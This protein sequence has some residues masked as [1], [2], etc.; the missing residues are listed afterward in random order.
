MAVAG[1]RYRRLCVVHPTGAGAGG[2][3]ELLVDPAD[4]VRRLDG[5]DVV[6]G[7]QPGERGIALCD[8]EVSRRH[9]ELSHD[10]E[11]DM[12][13]VRDLGSTNGTF[14]DGR[15]IESVHLRPGSVVRV[16]RSVFVYAEIAFPVI[17]EVLND[18]GPDKSLALARAELL[19]DLA[20][21]SDA[22]VLIVGPT[23][24]GKER[25]ARRVH[26]ES[27][28]GGA[29][30]PVNCATLNRELI[31]SELFGH[32]KGAFS[33]AASDRSG[34]FVA[35][36]GGTLFLDEIGDLPID[37]QPALLRVIEER[38]IRPVGSD[39]LRPVDVRIVSA[40]HRPLDE[41][42]SSERFRPDL[43]SRLS[44]FRVEL[45]G[46]DERREEILHLFVSMLGQA[47]RPLADDAAEALLVH[48]WPKNV[49]E[50]QQAAAH[51]QLFAAKVDQI[52]L[53]LLPEP[54]QRAA[55]RTIDSAGTDPA[56]PSR[57]TLVDLLQ[58]HDGNVAAVARALGKGRQQVYRW[59]Q[60]RGID[61]AAY[62]S[63]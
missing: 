52:D 31:G 61:P 28:R 30:I 6:V 43:H 8:S 23:G 59:M 36:D 53:G 26:D 1:V 15:R 32:V 25:L 20:A 37:Q 58:T 60:A 13:R 11:L 40:T 16:G 38:T 42:E 22:P 46:L 33:G 10:A 9:A 41:L 35:A 57:Q 21:P 17:S 18:P 4:R 62:R 3:G 27:G 39:R 47:A 56:A 12:Y 2:D 7:R 51:A 54:I 49:R 48:D 24:A 50:L 29:F 19:V 45:P 5:Q 34:L 14:V 55:A 63:S 44:G